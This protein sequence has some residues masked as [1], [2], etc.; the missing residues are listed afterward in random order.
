MRYLYH[1]SKAQVISQKRGR[2][3]ARGKGKGWDVAECCLLGKTHPIGY[4]TL[5]S[6]NYTRLDSQHFI[7]EHEGYTRPC[8]SLNGYGH[9]I[10]AV[11]GRDIFL[12]GEVTGELIASYK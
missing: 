3:N 9:L 1:H 5:R 10:I 2:K 12:S 8:P 4:S 11:G 6:C 7:M